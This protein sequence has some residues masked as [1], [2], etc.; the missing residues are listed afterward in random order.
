VRVSLSSVNFRV[1]YQAFMDCLDGLLPYSFNDIAFSVLSY[2]KNSD[3]LS[4]ASKRR[5]AMI[6]DYG[7]TRAS[8][9]W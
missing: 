5:L 6:G 8:M 2:D 9:W 1:K 4:P 3:Q 7:R